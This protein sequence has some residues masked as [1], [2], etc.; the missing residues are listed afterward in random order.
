MLKINLTLRMTFMHFT[1]NST[2]IFFCWGLNP[3]FPTYSASAVPL[4]YTPAQQNSLIM[5]Y[6]PCILLY[7]D[8]HNKSKTIPIIQNI[9]NSQQDQ[10]ANHTVGVV[11]NS[12]LLF[13]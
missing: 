3:G 10:I 11:W 4:S 8:L 12:H 6:K 7:N 9:L 13:D 5:F 2:K 1:Q